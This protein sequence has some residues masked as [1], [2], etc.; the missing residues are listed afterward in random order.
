[1]RQLIIAAA[2]TLITA[3]TGITKKPI[4]VPI[5]SAAPIPKAENQI[6]KKKVNDIPRSL[7]INMTLSNPDDLK[8]KSGQ[9]VKAG[10]VLSDRV[11]ERRSLLERKKLLEISLEEV[12]RIIPA[13]TKPLQLPG[14]PELPKAD[15]TKEEVAIEKAKLSLDEKAQI[16]TQQEEL[17]FSLQNSQVNN[18][19]ILHEEAK[20]NIAK[21]NYLKSKVDLDSA[22]AQLSSVKADRKYQE[23][24]HNLEYQN[25]LLELQ[26]QQN[27][28][29]LANSRYIEHVK[30]QEFRK[31]SL[32]T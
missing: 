19:V 18:D 21:L 7:K 29:E 3:C 6:V 31:A 17:I 14:M 12:G 24:R 30:E 15:F 16:V 2:L 32:N 28:Y 26:R 5:P 4:P 10:E 25:R 22:L 11:G 8:V 27:N 13:P 20:L 1:M 23:Y 9:L